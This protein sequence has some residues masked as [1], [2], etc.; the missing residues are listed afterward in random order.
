MHTARVLSCFASCWLQGALCP[1][2]LT[3]RVLCWVT[4]EQLYTSSFCYSLEYVHLKCNIQLFISNVYG[5]TRNTHSSWS[6]SRTSL[7]AVSRNAPGSFCFLLLLLLILLMFLLILLDVFC[8]LVGVIAFCF[9]CSCCCFCWYCRCC[10]C[11]TKL[12]RAKFAL[13]V[14]KIYPAI[15]DS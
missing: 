9:S 1:L 2:I 10:L 5:F 13:V 14:R 11:Y 7:L 15:P 4:F 6:R 3:S 12:Y 8:F